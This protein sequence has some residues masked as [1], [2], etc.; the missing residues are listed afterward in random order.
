MPATCSL[1][2]S[3]AGETC[4]ESVNTEA[5]HQLRDVD[6]VET[7]SGKERKWGRNPGLGEVSRGMIF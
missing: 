3:V 5:H 2:L 1:L 4:F 7:V 6:M